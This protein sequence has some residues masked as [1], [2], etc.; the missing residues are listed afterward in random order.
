MLPRVWSRR[1]VHAI[2][3]AAQCVTVTSWFFDRDLEMTEFEPLARVPP[4]ILASA[5]ALMRALAGRSSSD[6]G[7]AASILAYLA[8]P[9]ART[10]PL[11]E[12]S[13]LR[14]AY[15]EPRS[16]GASPDWRAR[17]AADALVSPV[18]GYVVAETS[19][20]IW[21]E[22]MSAAHGRAVNAAAATAGFRMALRK[23]PGVGFWALHYSRSHGAAPIQDRA[24]FVS[25]TRF[26]MNSAGSGGA[27]AVASMVPALVV[28]TRRRRA[29]ALLL[30]SRASSSPV[31]R[32]LVV[33]SGDA[34]DA[35]HERVWQRTLRA[36]ISL[37]HAS[38]VFHCFAV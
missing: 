5:P 21:A 12:I 35:A 13:P 10:S 30:C 9:A 16:G 11:A 32:D 14:G 7:G 23:D 33:Y 8:G 28:P 34:E 19:A 37:Q 26:F 18:A 29:K 31:L 24:T 20:I 15:R 17:L 38:L 2:P 36:A 22:R 4:A 6:A 25:R 27:D 3:T 1:A